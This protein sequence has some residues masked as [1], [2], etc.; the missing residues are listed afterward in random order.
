MGSG[1]KKRL[2]SSMK[3]LTITSYLWLIFPLG[4]ERHLNYFHVLPDTMRSKE[5]NEA[6]HAQNSD[7]KET[8][9]AAHAQNST[10]Q[11]SDGTVHDAFCPLSHCVPTVFRLCSDCSTH[12][13]C[14]M[15]RCWFPGVFFPT[16]TVK[17]WECCPS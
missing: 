13:F 10:A 17:Y 1:A 15:T 7:G 2:E 12:T 6:A 4:D 8:N 5:T 3:R 11:N 9:E 14:L 16:N